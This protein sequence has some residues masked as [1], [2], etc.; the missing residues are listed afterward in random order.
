MNDAIISRDGK[1][2]YVLK[3]GDTTIPQKTLCWV[4]LNPSTADASLDDPTIRRCT[5][6]TESFGYTGFGVVNLFALRAT[7]PAY[8]LRH[9]NPVGPEN[10]AYIEAVSMISGA[11]VLAWGAHKAVQPQRV[12]RV[13]DILYEH[14]IVAYCL[15]KTASGAPKHPLYLRN[16]TKLE[17]Y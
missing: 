4:M 3:R 13:L 14:H 2:R 15:G 17:V 10:D 8:L 7:D 1:Y 11:V 6:F 12:Q 9:V 5:R 16:D